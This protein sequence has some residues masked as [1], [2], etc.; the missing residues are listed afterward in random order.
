MPIDTGY[1]FLEDTDARLK[2]H[3]F[4]PKSYEKTPLSYEKRAVSYCFALFSYDFALIS[5][6]FGLFS[7]VFALISYSF[8]L[9]SYDFG[10]K[11]YENGPKLI[12]FAGKQ[13]ACGSFLRAVRRH[14][15]RAACYTIT[16][17]FI[18]RDAAI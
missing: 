1:W 18:A 4:V 14:T 7:Y 8:A 17:P 6:D 5:Y 15:Q 12:S 11:Q 3:I 10:P 16:Q 13:V 2:I 9:F